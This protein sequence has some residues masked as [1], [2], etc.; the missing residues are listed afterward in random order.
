MPNSLE[1]AKRFMPLIDAI[2]KAGS[3]T[4]GMDA[5]TRVDF[6]GVNEVKVLKVSTTG[7]GDYSRQ[8]G[9]PKGD[10]TAAWE[11]LQLTEER[12]KELSI[13]RMDNEEV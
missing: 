9:Y 7:L 4:Q 2:Y 6:T 8:N 13:D 11:T 3:V 10:V 12:G 1:Y 5:A